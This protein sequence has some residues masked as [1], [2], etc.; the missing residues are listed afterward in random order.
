MNNGSMKR[1]SGWLS[2]IIACVI[3]VIAY[4]LI[5]GEP[6]GVAGSLHWWSIVVLILLWGAVSAVIAMIKGKD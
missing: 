5:A 3:Y 4:T 1:H 6:P 2:F